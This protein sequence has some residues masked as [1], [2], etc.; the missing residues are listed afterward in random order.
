MIRRLA[1]TGAP[2][3]AASLLLTACSTDEDSPAPKAAPAQHPVFD[4]KLDRQLLLAVRQTRK[5]GSAG[6]VQKLTFTSGRGDAVQTMRGRMDF[7]GS[8][9]QADVAWTMPKGLP[10][11]TRVALVGDTPGSRTG[12]ASGTYLID[13]QGIHYRAASSAYWIR[14]T[15][16]DTSAHEGSDRLEH[17]RGTEAPVGGT[18]L[19]GISG[20]E[21]SSRN[22]D[23][24]GRTYRAGMPFGVLG[25]M[26]P[27]DLRKHLDVV[28]GGTSASQKAVPLTVG[29]DRQGRI[30]RARADLTRLLRKDGAL[31]GFTGLTM[32]LTLTGLGA[33]PPV[34]SPTGT[35]RTAARDVL[36]LRDVK[37]GG[38]VDFD[39]GQRLAQIVVGVPCSGPY[40]A[41]VFTQVPLR[42]G[43]SAEDTQERSDIAC[44]YAHDVARP[45][46]LPRVAQIWGWWTP[47]PK[48]G[49]KGRVTCY[50]T[51]PRGGA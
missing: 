15:A 10:H 37:D 26:F 22:D 49:A 35:V 40:D 33:T 27:E 34:A 21:A 42:A 51:S 8:R 30:T 20:A 1:R 46:W 2:L 29:V 3:L 36:P 14:Y 19:E 32:D 43:T 5:A 16:A 6:F 44:A 11:S 7:A 18:L 13:G 45:A 41:R 47:D 23:A 25:A 9:G 12:A 4:Q 50:V 17:L 28:N 39:T 31:S 38:C 24:T 48:G